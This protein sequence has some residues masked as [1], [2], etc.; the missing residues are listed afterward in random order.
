MLGACDQ[1]VMEWRKGGITQTQADRDWAECNHKADIAAARLEAMGGFHNP[2]PRLVD[3][4]LEARGYL[5]IVEYQAAGS[6][7]P[8]RGI[9][10][11]GDFCPR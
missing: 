7:V 4:C 5:L 2:R 3:M 8:R 11:E 6:C 10:V 1:L 9:G